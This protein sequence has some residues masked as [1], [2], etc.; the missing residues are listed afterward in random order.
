[1]L[2]P[3][4]LLS[5][6]ATGTPDAAAAPASYAPPP[7]AAPGPS[8]PPAL[9]APAPSAAPY[10]MP[11]PYVPK[12]KRNEVRMLAGFGTPVGL[13]GCEVAHRL[14]ASFEIA[15]GLGVGASAAQSQTLPPVPHVLQWAVMPRYQTTTGRNT[16][17]V[18]AG[19]SGGQY[20]GFDSGGA[21]FNCS[22]IPGCRYPTRYVL[23]ANAEIGYE[24]LAA[25]GYTLRFFGGASVGCT[26]ESCATSVNGHDLLQPYAGMG[27]GNPF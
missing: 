27:L 18:G 17:S 13:W 25:G 12:P 9:Y 24:H 5:L 26:L 2:A 19:V 16:A 15:A 3:A 6:L 11:A 21:S 14:G 22:A 1:M 23:W 8:A 7:S 4:L 20:G 10:A